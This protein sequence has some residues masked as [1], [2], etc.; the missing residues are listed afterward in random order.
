MRELLD[1]VLIKN[2]DE[3]D[4]YTRYW[5]LDDALEAVGFGTFHLILLVLSGVGYAA[6]T[7]EIA[8]ISLLIPKI[9]F[10]IK[11][12]KFPIGYGDYN[13][14]QIPNNLTFL[15][16]LMISVV[17]VGQ[18]IGGMIWAFLA[19]RWGR[20]KVFLYTTLASTLLGIMCSWANSLMML[21]I[22]RFF[23]GIAIGGS[24]SIDFVF[25]VECVA[26]NLRGSHSS[27]L[28]VFGILGGKFRSFF[29]FLCFDI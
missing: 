15:I 9:E 22:M 7:V 3:N 5:T 23:L 24:L 13:D 12:C 21:I 4:I 25:F 16:G 26:S 29:A 19:D 14:C 27:F 18:F 11:S 17:A 2:Q 20:R 6:G 28:I 8:H 1:D 10:L